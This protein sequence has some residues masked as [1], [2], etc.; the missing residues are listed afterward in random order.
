MPSGATFTTPGGGNAA[1]SIRQEVHALMTVTAGDMLYVGQAYRARIVKRT[2]QGTDVNGVPFAAYSQ[3][4][5]YYF[6]PNRE[7]GAA[8]GP[9]ATASSRKAR[10][11]A[12]KGRQRLAKGQ[13][14]PYG[15]RYASYGAAKAAHGVGNVNLYGMEQHTHMLD[16]IMVRA[17]GS[18]LPPSSGGA[19]FGS[20]FSSFEANTPENNLAI[21]F[22]GPEAERARGNN[23]GVP[24]VNL[25]KREFFAL[26]D[27]DLR[28]GE[29]AIGQRM[30]SRAQAGSSGASPASNVAQYQSGPI[31]ID[32]VGF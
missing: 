11:T 32:D 22:Y 21:G 2:L 19:D 26:N 18:E 25:P 6:Y 27:M 13:R 9:K 15:I 29:R 16:T 17:G 8:H 14:T 24:K 1:I 23:E 28:V 31:T 30:M 3:K 5:P 4:G 20:E 10:A 7:V 12:A